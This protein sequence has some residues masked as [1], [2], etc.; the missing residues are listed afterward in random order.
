MN[1]DDLEFSISQYLDGSLAGDER[2]ALERRLAEDAGARAVLEEYRQLDAA[3]KAA[4]L[5]EVRWEL[6]AS[7][8]SAAVADLADER[9]A[10]SYRFP[11]FVRRF[12]PLA[13]AASV[14]IAAG[15]AVRVYVARPG[16]IAKTEPTVVQPTQPLAVLNVEGP[17]F[18]KAQGPADVQIAIGP[19]KSVS[20]DSALA[21]YSD[22]V[23]SRPSRISVASGATPAQDA[24]LPIFDM[25]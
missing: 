11:A 22:D 1:N 10:T 7:S 14:L 21:Q 25:Q 6:L 12:A 16:Q 13:L 4:P 5:P 9:A 15:L 20:D 17:Q 3:M 18:E 19:G 24:P 8:I 2:G 23:V